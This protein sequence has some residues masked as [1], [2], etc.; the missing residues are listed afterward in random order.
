MKKSK[1]NPQD[2]HTPGPW[3]VEGIDILGGHGESCHIATVALLGVG[4]RH[5]TI[6]S[7]ARLIAAAPEL[8][9]AAKKTVATWQDHGIVNVILLRAAICKAEGR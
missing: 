9:E 3:I 6:Q 4:E 2:K 5:P 8:L 7:N 1:A